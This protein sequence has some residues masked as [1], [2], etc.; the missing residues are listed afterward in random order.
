[1]LC[2]VA[3]QAGLLITLT[4]G[5]TSV[6]GSSMLSNTRAVTAAHCWWDGRSQARSFLLVFGSAWLFSGGVRVSTTNVQ[7]HASWN[8]NNLNNDIAIIIF[9]SVAYTSQ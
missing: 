2:C 7:M 1:M 6:C 4:T 3:V 5:A 9:P 8:P